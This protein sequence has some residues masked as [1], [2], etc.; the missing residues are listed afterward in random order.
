MSALD[1]DSGDFSWYF[2]M[3]FLWLSS[4]LSAHQ[5]TFLHQDQTLSAQTVTV[6]SSSTCLGLD[7]G[8]GLMWGTLLPRLLTDN[9][10]WE[11]T[12]LGEVWTLTFIIDRWEHTSHRFLWLIRSGKS[13][14]THFIQCSYQFIETESH[15]GTYYSLPTGPRW[16]NP[17][18]FC[19]WPP[20]SP[21]SWPG[22]KVYWATRPD[23]NSQTVSET[24]I[25]S[26]RAS[27]QIPWGARWN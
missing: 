20:Y 21:T 27:P 11:L 23:K 15:F 4:F 26:C 5:V 9:N 1:P 7:L 6:H 10:K 19:K 8:L 18:P 2:S 25:K 3:I 12:R 17:G 16:S 14:C 24:S 13:L 22:Y